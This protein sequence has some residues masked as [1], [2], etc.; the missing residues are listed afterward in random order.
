MLQT[1]EPMLSGTVATIGAA[2]TR[3]RSLQGIVEAANFLW[4]QLSCVDFEHLNAPSARPALAYTTDWLELEFDIADSRGRRVVLT[5]RQ[6]VCFL[7]GD[8]FAVRDL[9]WGEGEQL[10]RYRARGAHRVCVVAEG[11]KRAI[12]LGPDQPAVK[13]E[14]R[15]FVSRRTIR[16]GFSG[17]DEYCEAFL[18][19]P[20]G[21][22]DL[23]V[24]FPS[25]RPPQWAHLTV[26]APEPRR[27]R[28]RVRY[29][30]DGRAVLRC[31]IPE[32]AIAVTYS[33]RWSW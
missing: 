15:T 30:A 14:H 13:G 1:V 4:R 19:R 16:D 7:I 21:R 3:I 2:V 27:R 10:A 29:G 18:E 33:L 32:P 9:V 11:S 22:L 31:R 8:C 23:T 20:T 12:I 6:R 24:R 26:A 25:T 28:I 5:R 17:T